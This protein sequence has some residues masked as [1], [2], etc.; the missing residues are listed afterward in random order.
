MSA[1]APAL[2]LG[3]TGPAGLT[4][5]SARRAWLVQADDEALVEWLVAVAKQSR[6]AALEQGSALAAFVGVPHGEV[7]ASPFGFRACVM[8]AA[9]GAAVVHHELRAQ[10]RWDPDLSPQDGASDDAHGTW[11]DGVLHVGR[12]EGFCQDLPFATFNPN[13]SARWTPHE[14]LHRVCGFAWRPELSR[15]FL[16]NAARLGEIVPVAHWYGPDL[17]LRLDSDGFDRVQDARRPGAE[18]ADA[19]WLQGDDTYLRKRAEVG[20]QFLRE[21]A[22]WL[23]RELSAVRAQ[24]RTSEPVSVPDALLNS[25][26]D[27]T[28]YTA[29]H[30]ARLSHPFVGEVLRAVTVVGHHR[31]AALDDY[32]AHQEHVFDQLLFG[33]LVIEPQ[34]AQAQRAGRILWDLCLTAALCDPLTAQEVLADKLDAVEAASKAAQAGDGDLAAR[35]GQQIR[36]SLTDAALADVLPLGLPAAIDPLPPRSREQLAEGLEVVAPGLAAKLLDRGIG[37]S[38]FCDALAEDVLYRRAPWVVRIVA[39]TRDGASSFHGEALIAQAV[40]AANGR[41]DMTERVSA[42]AGDWP[43][44]LDGFV[45]R[46]N[47]VFVCV[48]EPAAVLVGRFGDAVSVVPASAVVLAVWRQLA[49]GPVDAQTCVALADGLAEGPGQGSEE[50]PDDGRGWL[51]A[52]ALAGVVGVLPVA[53]L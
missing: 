17:A 13:H 24:C 46:R 23:Q 42:P 8:G 26:S 50:L 10:W 25:V 41:D 53:T 40:A 16:F 7:V 33:E 45:V 39:A 34:R 22:L 35:L 36:E 11:I 43:A 9:V 47:P 21:G 44:S 31:F 2:N 30:H 14:L 18:L 4:D 6:G 28:A 12:F 5:A 19:L 49:D 27:A 20:A 48:P 52:L 32:A 1:G 29:G 38:R 51:Q 15:W 3:A 37:A